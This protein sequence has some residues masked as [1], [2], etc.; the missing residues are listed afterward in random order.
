MDGF[1]PLWFIVGLVLGVLV[2]GTV[3]S[4]TLRLR[5]RSPAASD[6]EARPLFDA[7][8][9]KNAAAQDDARVLGGLL[10]K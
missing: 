8:H 3:I 10:R 7:Y 9:D 6:A 4:F 5:K 1:T 2:T